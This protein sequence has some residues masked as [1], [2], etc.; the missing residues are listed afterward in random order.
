MTVAAPT[1]KT[2]AIHELSWVNLTRARVRAINKHSHSRLPHLLISSLPLLTITNDYV[3]WH[4]VRRRLSSLETHERFTT[5]T[6]KIRIKKWIEWLS[7]TVICRNKA[8]L[9]SFAFDQNVFV[10]GRQI[11]RRFHWVWQ[12][13]T[14]RFNVSNLLIFPWTCAPL[15]HKINLWF[16]DDHHRCHHCSALWAVC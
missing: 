1:T 9:L 10:V 12:M 14:E 3:L 5:N 8:T 16:H 2:H 11:T 6:T 7:C 15:L 4:C 13:D